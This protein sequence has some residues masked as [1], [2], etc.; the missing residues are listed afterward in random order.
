MH[1]GFMSR[2]GDKAQMND[3]TLAEVVSFWREAGPE[4]WFRKEDGFDLTIRLRFRAIHEA[5]AR[6]EL[7]A[8]EK[9]PKGALAL[10]I[11]LDHVSTEHVSQ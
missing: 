7:A 11:L 4:R 6:G 10:V 5:A 9:S 8:M 1:L 2:S 3:I